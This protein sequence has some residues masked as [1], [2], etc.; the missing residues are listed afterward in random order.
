MKQGDEF[1]VNLFKLLILLWS[2]IKLQLQ[3]RGKK[4]LWLSPGRGGK[5][6]CFCCAVLLPICMHN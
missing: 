6:L 3:R 5:C 2:F 4:R 1:P